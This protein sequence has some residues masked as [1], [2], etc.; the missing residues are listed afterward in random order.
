MSG[1][2]NETACSSTQ[3]LQLLQEVTI[4]T[5][6]ASTHGRFFA[7]TVEQPQW[8]I[9]SWLCAG[10]VKETTLSHFPQNLVQCVQYISMDFVEL[11]AVCA[12]LLRTR[13]KRRK[14]FW[15]HPLVSQRLLKGQYHK[16][17]ED[18]RMHPKTKSLDVL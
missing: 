13:A 3:L 2:I 5:F 10:T 8:P 9:I 4:S 16:L 15:V 11:V 12:V 7:A 14:W 6:R 18:L 17:C 1:F